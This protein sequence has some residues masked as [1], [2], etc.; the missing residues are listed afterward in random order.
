MNGENDLIYHEPL[1]RVLLIDFK[2]EDVETL[3]KTDINFKIGCYP[4]KL[5]LPGLPISEVLCSFETKQKYNEIDI[6]FLYA[7]YPAGEKRLPHSFLAEGSSI[8]CKQ[9][10]DFL[11]SERNGFF[12]CFLGH[13]AGPSIQR[14]FPHIEVSDKKFRVNRT[15]HKF[16]NEFADNPFFNFVRTNFQK[17][18]AYYALS[19]VELSQFGFAFEV[20]PFLLD[21][22]G[23]QYAVELC[24]IWVDGPVVPIAVFLPVYQD[25]PEQVLYILEKILPK[26]KPNLFPNIVDFNYLSQDEFLPKELIELKKE[27]RHLE[28]GY[29]ETLAKYEEKEN[30]IKKEKAYLTDLLAQK[31]DILK[32]S[33]K[34][35][36]EEILK[37]VG[38]DLTVADVDI[39]DDM[40]DVD[41]RLKDDLR[42]K[43][44][45]NKIIL[46]DVKGT[47]KVFGQGPLNQLTEHRRIFLKHHKKDYH[48]DDIHSLGLLN[49]ELSVNPKNRGEVFGAYSQD[50]LERVKSDEFTII[51]TYELF[52]LHK[53]LS[54]K[55]VSA[56]EEQ[57]LTFLTHTGINTFEK[58]FKANQK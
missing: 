56:N 16:V 48:A 58:F 53:A 27:K 21:D 3:K 4:L 18:K 6:V 9:F 57:V 13:N 45:D 46:I 28:K 11:I 7:Q 19:G 20:R 42:I 39:E 23:N 40:K 8:G 37:V 54:E 50:A 29:H 25:T 33:C 10:V 41:R 38:S 51:G 14:F 30:K 26:I 44:Q 1:P 43:L 49:H 55:K 35:V 12:V 17:A 5:S 15:P 36:L 34:R 32:C 22:M 24:R 31:H 52:K 47:D 2:P